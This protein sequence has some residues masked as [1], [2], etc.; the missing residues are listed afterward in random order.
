MMT[1]LMVNIADLKARLS[2]FVEAATR[3]ERVVIC[4]RNKPVAELRSIEHA[5]AQPRDL[6]PMYPDW[7]IDRAFFEPLPAEELVF[8]ETGDPPKVS[9]VAEPR[10][11]YGTARTHRRRG[12]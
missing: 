5:P 2:E 1:M 8:W 6:S 12:K 3:G 11:S 7:T 4:N 9:H 10:A